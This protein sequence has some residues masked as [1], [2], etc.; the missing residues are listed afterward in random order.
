MLPQPDMMTTADTRRATPL[1]DSVQA[2]RDLESRAG[3][4][5]SAS[6]GRHHLRPAAW[7]GLTLALAGCTTVGPDFVQPKAPVLEQWQEADTAVVTRKPAE[8]IRWWEGFGDPV[9]GKLIE[10]AYRNNYNLKIAGLRVLEARAQLGVAVGYLYPQVQQ[11]NG[12]VN[13]TAASRNAANTA[14]GDLRFWEYNVGV[15]VGWELDFWGKFRRSIEAADAN[16]LASIAG[17][18]NVLVLLVA[19]VADTYVAI[20]S[21]EAQLKVAREN[22]AIQQR[23]VRITEARFRGG[24]VGEL[25]VLQAR[26]QLLGTQATIP[27]LETG[28]QQAKNALST[29]LGQPPGS[30]AE[31]MGPQPGVIPAAPQAIAAGAPTDLLRRRPDVRQAE[32]AAATQSA[33]VGVAEADLYPS[34]G[35]SG[36]LGVVAADGTNTTRT[37]NS[38][39]GQLFNANSLAFFG[40]PYFSWNILNYGRIRNNVRVKDAQLQQLL[41]NYQS[42]VLNAVKEVEDGMVAFLHSREQE[43]IL[44]E[45]EVS[46]QRSLT[47]ANVGYREGLSDFQ[48]VLDAQGALL[49]A[50][51]QLVTA[52]STTV[53][54]AVGIYRALGG[55]WEIRSGQGFVD[56]TTRDTMQ[57]RVDWGDLLE[58]KATEPPLK[59]Q[60]SGWPSP[61]W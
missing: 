33:V 29:L 19:Q 38:G 17:Y 5:A 57:R 47:L 40:G 21:A 39:P 59:G 56:E 60:G 32:L 30:L 1:N 6:G 31:I 50:Q 45:T 26:T 8:Q 49:R 4:A 14:A 52:R 54:S 3:P 35:L 43:R 42:T 34:F 41:E 16:L 25:D 18:D 7:I 20:R 11:A 15:S 44:A 55:G 58:P 13:Y 27:P 28:L 10:I 51:Q 24:D 23:S 53:S 46:A 22:I 48:R 37:G 61:D 12:S 2:A 9:L 36:F